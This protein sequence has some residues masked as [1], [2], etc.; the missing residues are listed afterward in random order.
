[1][2]MNGHEGN[3]TSNESYSI[4]FDLIG[5]RHSGHKQLD[6]QKGTQDTG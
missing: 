6:V 2:A 4:Y 1:M 3:T 5:I